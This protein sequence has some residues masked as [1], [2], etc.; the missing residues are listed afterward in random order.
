MA[1]IALASTLA[2]GSA[3]YGAYP[4]GNG[5]IAFASDRDAVGGSPPAPELY[6]ANPDGSGL[7]RLTHDALRQSAPAWS[8]DGG[9]LAYT[10][11]NGARPG[12]Y[13][14]DVASGATSFVVGDALAEV[15][16]SVSWSPDGTRLV[17]A[18]ASGGL[19]IVR[20]DGTG[21]ATT[22]RST[23][24][25]PS[26]SPDGTRIAFTQDDMVNGSAVVRVWS[27]TPDGSDPRLLSPGL[28]P[29]W[30]PDGKR[31]A[32]SAHPAS[33]AQSDRAE[34]FTMNADGS[35]VQ[36]ITA[37]NDPAT[38]GMNDR[39]FG[40]PAWSPDGT[41]I[42]FDGLSTESFGDIWV[43]GADGN[44]KPI[45]TTGLHDIGPS[46]QPVPGAGAPGSSPGPPPVAGQGSTQTPPTSP[47]SHHPG[48][49]V[50]A[51][52][53]TVA[54]TPRRDRR[55]PFRYTI[56]GKVLLPSA[57]TPQR[58]CTGRVSVAV[59]YRA[60]TVSTRHAAVTSACRYRVTVR[61]P[62]RRLP[63]FGRLKVTV[64]FLGNAALRR[65]TVR[66]IFVRFG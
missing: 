46:W 1:T 61:V 14:L 38:P 22:I 34:V 7:T 41:M 64:R 58:G 62:S 21:G 20:A 65:T 32:F 50:A 60:R 18:R 47:A 4:G 33:A 45:T 63:R 24:F 57:V 35:G 39:W 44:A 66:P 5:K 12:L 17:Y 40:H 43:L 28:D 27:I 55:P 2:G 8:P 15:G 26:W 51:R 19:A 6:L 54:A 11:S 31:L 29:D 48:S 59:K 9:R 49:R 3:A 30:S 56:S 52:A 36:Q 42:T 37:L 25:S 16:R 13:V 53:V 23:G 10:V